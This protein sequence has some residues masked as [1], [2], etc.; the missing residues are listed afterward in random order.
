MFKVQNLLYLLIWI[1]NIFTFI[2]AKRIDD[3]Y[4]DDIYIDDIYINDKKNYYKHKDMISFILKIIPLF[5]MLCSIVL[6][7]VTIFLTNKVTNT[8]ISA[9]YLITIID[10]IFTGIINTIY[11]RH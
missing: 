5:M 7:I 10:L 11:E 6:A 2:L 9:Y 8:I 4:I 1:F 3:I